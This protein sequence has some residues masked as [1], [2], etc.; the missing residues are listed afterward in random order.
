MRLATSLLA[1]ALA[2]CASYAPYQPQ[3]MSYS[4]IEN[5]KVTN[6]DCS[7][8]DRIIE[9]INRQLYLKGYVGK[10]PEDLPSEEDRKYNSRARVVVWSLRIG[11]NNPNRY[12]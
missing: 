11:C 1:V 2:G 5:I 9:N 4:E 7:R 8:I 6:N 10:N 12:K 3:A